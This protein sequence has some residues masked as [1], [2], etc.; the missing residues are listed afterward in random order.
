MKKICVTGANG[1]IGQSI[2]KTLAESNKS[3]R[4][5]VRNSNPSL[6][7]NNIEYVPVGDMSLKINW[8]D[9]LGGMDCIIHCAGKTNTMNEKNEQD[10]FRLINVEGTKQLAEQAAKSGVKRLV[11]LSSIKVN[12][13]GAY[14]NHR[15]F[16]SDNQKKKIFKYNDLPN[17]QDSYAISKF[18]AEKVLWEISLK[19]ELEITVVRIPLVY[20]YTAKGNLA[21]LQKLVGYGIPLPFR[22]VKNQRSM[23]GIDNLVNLLI[24]CIDHPDALGKTF[25][26]SDGEDLSTSDLINFIASSMGRAPLLFPV[27]IF[28]L[29]FVGQILGK[30]KRN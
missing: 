22:M 19:T 29:K 9:F 7:S 16:N 2:C 21:R 17:P 1:F 6:N 3:V 27:P 20:G 12:G 23:I 24:R 18:E 5:F 8:K 25:L 13:E 10:I 11:F 4:G 28:L 14:I 30:K 15:N 26:V